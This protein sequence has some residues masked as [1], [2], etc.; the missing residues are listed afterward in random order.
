MPYEGLRKLGI[1]KEAADCLPENVKRA[2]V[3]G[4]LTPLIQVN[5]RTSNGKEFSLPL[6]LQLAEGR[7]GQPVLMAYP[8]RTELS[9]SVN[10]LNLSTYE[11]E[12]LAE[13]SVLLKSLEDRNGQRHQTFLQLDRETNSLM[14][15]NITEVG[16]EQKLRDM[17]KVN[18]IELGQ[19]QKEAVRE[20]KPVELNV[21]GE[22]VTVGVD[23]REPQGFRIVN[24]DMKEWDRQQK[25]K[26]DVE[27]PE[28]VGLVQTDQNRWEY[29]QIVDKQSAERAIKLGNDRN[30][31][32][33][34][35]MKM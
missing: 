4:E 15:K 25:I 21:G 12:R 8:V 11:K 10:S 19:Q 31:G 9:R 20:G 34:D 6:K 13:G 16:L 29:K 1:N 24:G 14:K 7:G 22:K 18:D 3:Q 35:G 17:E 2:L 23:L 33:S 26:F 28:Y 30:A 5:I 27:H 32:V